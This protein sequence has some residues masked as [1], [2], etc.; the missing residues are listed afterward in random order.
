MR[1]IKFENMEDLYNFY[2]ELS[3]EELKQ[4]EQEL[5]VA[6]TTMIENPDIMPRLAI[7]SSIIESK[8]GQD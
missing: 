8:D 6:L 4:E 7:V 1:D 3:L 5:K 2:N